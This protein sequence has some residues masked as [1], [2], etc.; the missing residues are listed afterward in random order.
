MLTAGHAEY[1]VSA[2]RGGGVDRGL[3]DYAMA[4]VANS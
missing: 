3:W 1:R 4:N 2:F